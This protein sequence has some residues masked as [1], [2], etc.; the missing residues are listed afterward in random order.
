MHAEARSISQAPLSRS[1]LDVLN[2]TVRSSSLEMERVPAA[3]PLVVVANHPF[4]ILDGL[5]LDA[6]LFALRRRFW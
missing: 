2:V 6:A 3:G 1:V 4:G 5:A